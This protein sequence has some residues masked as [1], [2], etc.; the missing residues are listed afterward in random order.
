MSE[1][2]FWR[3]LGTAIGSA[4]RKRLGKSGKS[5]EQRPGSA[6]SSASSKGGGTGQARGRNQGKSERTTASSSS[7][8]Q[9]SASNKKTGSSQKRASSPPLSERYPGDF[10]G[11]PALSYAPHADQ[12]P[13]PGEVVWTWVPYEEDH[14]QGKDRPVLIVGLDG[15]WLL[16]LML[17]SQDHDVDQAQ[18][19]REG[20]FWVEVGTGAWD[21]Q[22]RVSE[23]RVDR[24]LRVDARKVRRIGGRLAEGI[25][26]R[27]A[28]GIREHA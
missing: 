10:R 23:A 3:T 9:R 16:G 11:V 20:R 27:V 26:D 17:T 6:T 21:P 8:Q 7:E 5:G 22:G 14:S 13:D 12:L 2:Q 4:L 25:F 24:I 18:E 28:A 19:N 1:Q 15:D